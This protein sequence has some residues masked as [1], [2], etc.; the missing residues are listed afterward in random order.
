[1]SLKRVAKSTKC[2]VMSKRLYPQVSAMVHYCNNIIIG[3][4]NMQYV[5]VHTT[6]STCM[7]MYILV[8]QF[9]YM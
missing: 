1:M 6:T 9:M 2:Q 7:Y 3:T 8:L 5:H 4:L